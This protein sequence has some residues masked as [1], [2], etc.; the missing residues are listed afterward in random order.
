MA[1]NTFFIRQNLSDTNIQ[2]G[3]EKINTQR[4]KTERQEDIH[5]TK[6]FREKET[7]RWR[8]ETDRYTNK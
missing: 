8:N 2:T 4:C 1:K 7:D 5:L 3:I 6:Q